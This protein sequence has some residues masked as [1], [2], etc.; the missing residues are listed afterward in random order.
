MARA[1]IS[2]SETLHLGTI[3]E[4]I[5]RP[6][7]IAMLQGLGCEMGQG[8]L[9][10]HPLGASEMSLFLKDATDTAAR[11]GHDLRGIPAHTNGKIAKTS[12]FQI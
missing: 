6:E 1:I 2:M 9:F 11:N 8:Y 5:E 12:A 3:A 10:A 4:G 7:Q